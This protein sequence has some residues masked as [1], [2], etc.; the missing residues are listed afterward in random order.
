MRCV[1]MGT[2][3]AG[4]GFGLGGV[5]VVVCE[6]A[7]CAVGGGLGFGWV[8]VVVCCM[9]WARE[10]LWAQ[11]MTT[12]ATCIYLS[13][14]HHEHQQH[15]V[16]ARGECWEHIQ[17]LQAVWPVWRGNLSLRITPWYTSFW[18]ARSIFCAPTS[19]STVQKMFPTCAA[20][21][22]A[23]PGSLHATAALFLF[24]FRFAQ[25]VPRKLAIKF[26]LFCDMN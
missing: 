25:K 18:V 4:L 5:V 8:V 21:W 23:R 20:C 26:D 14:I 13:T 7:V 9:E 22:T 17:A 15:C 10:S 2:P 11:E 3:G 6:C 16:V 1:R 19:A 12:N 24:S